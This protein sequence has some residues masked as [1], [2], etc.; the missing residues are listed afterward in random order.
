MDLVGRRFW[1][2][3]EWDPTEQDWVASVHGSGYLFV[4]GTTREE[5]LSRVRQ[6]IAACLAS[7]IG[8]FCA[9]QVTAP[10]IGCYV[11]VEVDERDGCCRSS[12]A[13]SAGCLAGFVVDTGARSFSRN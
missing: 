11:S 12:T 3:I 8:A 1:V 4:Y 13:A 7:G 5:A 2:H 6:A 9:D 10:S